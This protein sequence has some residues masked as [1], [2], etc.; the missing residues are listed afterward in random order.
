MKLNHS[1]KRVLSFLLVAVMVIG[2]W[3]LSAF[4][5]TDVTLTFKNGVAQDGANRYLLYFDHLNDTDVNK[6]WNNNTVYIDGKAVSGDGVHYTHLSDG[7]ALLLNYNVIEEGVTTAAE[8]TQSHTLQIK[9]GTSMANGEYT[10]ANDVWLKLDGYTVTQLTPVNL[11]HSGGGPQDAAARFQLK[12]SGFPD[13][14]DRYWNGMTVYIDGQP[15]SG[16]GV[17][18]LPDSSDG[19]ALYLSYSVMENVTSYVNLGTHILE[20]PAG[21]LLGSYVV[22]KGLKFQLSASGIKQI[23]DP[24]VTVTLSNDASRNQAGNATSGFYFYASPAD[25]L[26]SDVTNWSVRYSMTTGGTYVNGAEVPDAKL[27]KLTSNLYY[28]SVEGCNITY[29]AGDV[30]TVNGTVTSDGY[31]V[32]YTEASF[33]YDG[34]GNWDIYTGNNFALDSS[35][36]GGWQSANSRY[37]IWLTDDILGTKT[38]LGTVQLLIDGQTK[39]VGTFLSADGRYALLLNA[40]CGITEK[41][42]HIIRIAAGQALGEYTVLNDA[43]IYTHIDGSVNTIAPQTVTLSNDDSRNKNGNCTSGFYF[44]GSPADELASDVTNWSVRYSMTTGGIYVNGTVVPGAKLI[45]LTSSLYYVSVEGC[46][47]TYTAGDVV[48]VNGTVISNGYSVTY[49]E[50]SFQYD[51]NGNWDI[52]TPPVGN[53]FAL[54]ASDPGGWQSANSRYLVWLS[55]DISGDKTDLGTVQLLIDGETKNVAT[56]LIDGRYALILNADCGITEKGEHSIQITAGQTLGEYTVLNDVMIYTHEN[57]CVDTIAPSYVTLGLDVNDPGSWQTSNNRYLV[58]LTDDITGDKA[59][60]GAVT[61]LINGESKSIGTA[62]IDGRYV[63]VLD[64]SCG[65]SALGEYVIQFTEGQYFGKYHVNNDLIIYAHADGSVDQVA[66]NTDPVGILHIDTQRSGHNGTNYDV[67]LN[68]SDPEFIMAADSIIA[69]KVDGVESSVALRC[70]DAGT[71][72]LS[73]DEVISLGKHTVTI[74]VATQIGT[75]VL[76]A[77][78]SF[79]TYSGGIVGEASRGEITLSNATA[80]MGGDYGD[81]LYYDLSG[82]F[83]GANWLVNAIGTDG[84]VTFEYAKNIDNKD[85]SSMFYGVVRMENLQFIYPQVGGVIKIVTYDTAANAFGLTDVVLVYDKANHIAYYQNAAGVLTEIPGG[86]D[87]FNSDWNKFFEDNALSSVDFAGIDA[88]G[89]QHFGLG[90]NGEVDNTTYVVDWTKVMVYDAD[91]NDLGIQWH[92]SG[93]TVALKLMADY[94]KVI[95]LK[96]ADF[97]GLPVTGWKI[98]DREGNISTVSGTETNGVWA[99]TVPQDAMAIEP[100]YKTVALSIQDV[101]GNSLLSSDIYWLEEEIAKADQRIQEQIAAGN[102]MLGYELDGNLYPSLSHLPVDETI[103]TLAVTVKTLQFCVQEKAEIRHGED[104]S[105]SGLR[106]VATLYDSGYSKALLIADSE[107]ELNMENADF[108]VGDAISADFKQVMAMDGAAVYSI[109]LTNIP[110][111]DYNKTYYAVGAILV[112]YADGTEEYVYTET[113]SATVNE[114]AQNSVIVSDSKTTYTDGVMHLDA[115]ANLIGSYSYTT[116][117]S[118]NVNGDYVISYTGDQQIEALTIVGQKL[119]SEDGVVFGNGTI[120]VPA[121]LFANA[122]LQEELEEK[123]NTLQIAAYR[124]PSVGVYRYTEQ[125]GTVTDYSITRTHD[126]VYADVEDFFNA[127]FNVWMAEDWIYGAS[128]YGENDALSALDLAAE[129]CINHGLTNADIQVLVTDSLLNGLLEGYTMPENAGSTVEEYAQ[130]IA[131]RLETLKNYNPKVNGVAVGAE[132]NCFAGYL[133][134]DEPHYDHLKYYN[135]WFSFLGADTD[136]SISV[137]ANSASTGGQ[138]SGTVNGLG[139]LKDGYTLYFSMMGLGSAQQYIVS[140]STSGTACTIE[141]YTAFLKTFIDGVNNTVWNYSNMTLAFDSYGLITNVS[142]SYGSSSV[143]YTDA[144]SAHWQENMA[145]VAS[146]VEQKNPNSTFAT[147]LR[148][149]GMTRLN[150]VANASKWYRSASWTEFQKFDAAWGQQAIDQQA[151]A[152]LAHGYSYMSYFTYWEP[153][154]QSYNGETFTDACIMWDSNMNPVKQDMYYWV[155]NTNQELHSIENLIGNF[156]YSGTA[157][158]ASGS[159][160]YTGTD[161]MWTVSDLASNTAIASVS[162]SVDT[163]VGHYTKADGNFDEMFIIVNMSHPAEGSSNTVTVTFDGGYTSAIVYI[164]GE[165]TMYQLSGNAC[166]IQIPSGEGVIVIPAA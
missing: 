158:V 148:S 95:Y 45:K 62:L 48:T 3:P 65:I 115:K 155:M 38:N 68:M 103:D 31:T 131:Q 82:T 23:F 75:R 41:G 52:Y 117:V 159:S 49:T 116:Q 110:A 83:L 125:S 161:G 143:T 134:R 126:A 104:L 119:T 162:S 22:N 113:V 157:A 28:V 101:N 93:A 42:E 164:D 85:N 8:L 76:D 146:L 138:V 71:V 59:E 127:G 4:A 27:I 73:L 111:A 30:V 56:A 20:L 100:I 25:E 53:I 67:Y 63:L 107:D 154:H 109:A 91:G 17:H 57:G 108:K 149:F 105:D 51:G 120:T 118:N 112:T 130:I 14:V 69:V 84:D 60:V 70:D 79:C 141:Q 7:F 132:Y 26:A 121:A 36:P 147:A 12:F 160:F 34:N 145:L 102:V 44:Y 136:Q 10:V 47:I 87:L 21:T 86:S 140:G 98:T 150:M 139:M 166:T 50:E 77:D 2:M 94:G 80:M 90:W 122:L 89:A 33:Q 165:A 124:G 128:N 72:V 114:A 58:W 97:N 1:L 43:A 163:T 123:E 37:L 153:Q 19:I 29:V 92:E 142:S 15:V 24:D 133:L 135:G 81:G 9:S 18:F 64:A 156:S 137:I 54:D 78:F 16:E 144:M 74:P 35:D 151:Y 106:F 39:S 88:K 96:P 61:A 66:P 5:A 32:A 99:I 152:S 55:D 6:Y 129:Y 40:D 11:T 46:S 13:T